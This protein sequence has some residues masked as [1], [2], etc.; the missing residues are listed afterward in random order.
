MAPA[1]ESPCPDEA[2]L[3]RF[4]DGEVDSATREVITQHLA[5]CGDCRALVALAAEESTDT[6]TRLG[7]YRVRAELGRGAMGVVYAAEDPRLGR[8][9]AV[10]VLN[11]QTQTDA[12]RR[13]RLQR[14]AQAMAKLSH[15]NVVSVFDVGEEAERVYIVMEKVEGIDLRQ[16]CRGRPWTEILD[17]YVAAGRG[18]HAAHEAG[19]VHRDFKP[20]NVLIGD[21]GRA[22]VTDFGL[23]GVLFEPWS[24]SEDGLG[25][26]DAH[27]TRTNQAVGT[28]AYMSPEQFAGKTLSHASDQFSFCMALTEALTGARPTAGDSLAALAAAARRA[29]TSVDLSGRG[30]PLALTAVLRRGLAAK[31][32][33]RFASMERL[34]DALQRARSGRGPARRVVL[35]AV[36]VGVLVATLGVLAPR[37]GGSPGPDDAG[38]S[39]FVQAEVQRLDELLARV[40]RHIW[41]GEFAVAQTLLEPEAVVLESLAWPPTQ[42]EAELQWARLE[43]AQGRRHAQRDRLLQAYEDAGAHGL[44][45]QRTRAAIGLVDAYSSG[46]ADHERANHWYRVALADAVRLDDPE[47]EAQALRRGAMAAVQQS[48]FDDARSMVDRAVVRLRAEPESEHRL[49]RSDL[50]GISGFIGLYRG[51]AGAARR[52]FSSQ[53]THLEQVLGPG[54][55][56]SIPALFGLAQAAVAERSWDEAARILDERRTLVVETFGR[57]STPYGRGAAQRSLVAEG[58][59]DLEGALRHANEARSILAETLGATHHDVARRHA[60]IGDLHARRGD[61][62][63]AHAEHVRGLDACIEAVGSESTCALNGHARVGTMLLRLKRDVDARRAFN[64]ARELSRALFGPDDPS[65]IEADLGLAELALREG[66]VMDAGAALRAVLERAPETERGRSHRARATL[67]LERLGDTDSAGRD[68]VGAGLGDDVDAV[69]E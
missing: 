68:E 41:A 5:A 51:D 10:K 19:L 26:S 32:S 23:V 65:A 48:R 2:V 21:D 16:W 28:P 31:P 47:L 22:R 18:L 7:R 46:L 4:A 27:L 33:D 20:S 56:R 24:R 12:K 9:V 54:H 13:A 50:D 1:S 52:A 67:L 25:S 30:T 58:R 49:T 34:V 63:A 36:G 43:A 66:N 64:S 14:E 29:A 60:R 59:G 55:A 11:A 69:A 44:E 39:V 3:V 8:E 42:V 57:R 38:P 45:R 35:G 61:V 15:S 62:E 40:D 17:G 37:F 6:P 53:L